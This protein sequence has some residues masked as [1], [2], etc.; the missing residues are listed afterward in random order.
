MHLYPSALEAEGGIDFGANLFYLNKLAGQP[1][2][3]ED[4]GP[5]TPESLAGEDGENPIRV[6][7]LAGNWFFCAGLASLPVILV[8]RLL[9]CEKNAVGDGEPLFQ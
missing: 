2:S 4:M 5:P 3:D 8:Y 6:A 1:F 7:G 9:P